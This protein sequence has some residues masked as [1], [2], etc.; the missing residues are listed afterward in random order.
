MMLRAACV[1]GL[2]VCLV[3]GVARATT[4]VVRGADEVFWVPTLEQG[5]EM[6]QVSG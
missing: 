2:A 4:D 6:A 5:L 3:A 1:W